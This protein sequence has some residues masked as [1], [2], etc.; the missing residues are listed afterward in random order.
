[1]ATAQRLYNWKFPPIKCPP[2]C[3]FLCGRE[4][5]SIKPRIMLTVFMLFFR[6]G[7]KAL[8]TP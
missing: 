3:K 4:T 2:L 5:R 7:N 6:V 1:M 8:I